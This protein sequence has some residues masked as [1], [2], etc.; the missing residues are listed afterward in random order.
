MSIR[1]DTLEI[2]LS[3][4]LR[5]A[6]DL[7]ELTKPRLILMVLITTCVGFYLGS[8]EVL[9]YFSLIHTLMGTAL[10]AGGTLALNELIER[11]TD[12]CMERTRHRPLPEG[13]VQPVEALIFGIICTIAGLTLLAVTSNFLTAFITAL[14]VVSYLFLYTPLKQR[15]PLCGLV[16]AIPGALPPM[17]GWAAARGE[18]GLGAWILF[19]VLFCW[20][21][22]HS[23]AIARLYRDDFAR[24]KIQFL[25]VVD[26]DGKRTGRHVVGYTLALLVVS[27]LPSF[28]GL[29]GWLYGATAILL[30]ITFLACGISLASSQSLAHARRL[31]FASL[32]YLPMILLVMAIDRVLI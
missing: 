10:A 4:G 30:G 17:I 29:A 12:A 7:F 16:G 20:Q 18:L 24:A 25:P 2:T 13:R 26:P 9:V 5:W 32:I 14:I 15:T 8:G 21:I 11:R 19:G 23:L 28:F 22:P 1:T 27:L 3:G 31:L 6:S